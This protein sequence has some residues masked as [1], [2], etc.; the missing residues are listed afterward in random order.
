MVLVARALLFVVT[1]YL[2]HHDASVRPGIWMTPWTRDLKFCSAILD[3]AL[4]ALLIGAKQKNRVLLIL[5]GGLGIMFAGGAIGEAVRS[6]ATRNQSHLISTAG[7]LIV[8][9]ADLTLLY[10]LWQVFRKGPADEKPTTHTRTS[11]EIRPPEKRTY[12]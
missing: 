11:S 10:I 9:L 1:S 2:V 12:S 4:W 5:S 6:L 7:G 3:L 8:M